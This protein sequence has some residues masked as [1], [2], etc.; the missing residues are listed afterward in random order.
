MPPALSTRCRYANPN[1]SR[2]LGTWGPD[3]KWID[4]KQL[5]VHAVTD[6]ER[7]RNGYGLESA[8][9]ANETTAGNGISQDHNGSNRDVSQEGGSDR[10]ASVNRYDN[11]EQPWANGSSVSLREPPSRKQA[12]SG[13][14]S[15][16]GTRHHAERIRHSIGPT[17]IPTASTVEGKT[18]SDHRRYGLS[19]GMTVD[20]GQIE[21]SQPRHRSPLFS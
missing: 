9:A 12:R 17:P 6:D 21:V 7:A 19:P 3:G 18:S 14:S 5:H 1:R 15:G 16:P 8:M 20:A 4:A 10:V 11:R 2:I 13:S